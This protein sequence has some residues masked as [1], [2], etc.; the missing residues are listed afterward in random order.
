MTCRR[1]DAENHPLVRWL[2]MRLD[3]WFLTPQERGNPASKI[4]ALRNPTIAWTEGNRVTFLIDGATYFTRLSDVLSSLEPHDEVRFTDWRGD[5]DERV[6]HDGTS[7]A[8]LL[9]DACRRQVDV[10]GLLW[11]SH[12]D[13]FAFSSKENRRLAV[14]VSKSGGEVLLDERVRRAGSHHQKMFVVRHRTKPERDVALL[15][16]IDLS[17]GRHDD[18]RHHGDPQAIELDER[19]GPRPPWHDV[20]VE[21]QGPAVEEID[22][23]FHERW[24]DPTPLNHAGRARAFVSRTLKRDR[25]GRELPTRL[26]EPAAVGSHAVQILRTYPSRRPRYPFAPDGERS[27]ARAFS[28]ALARARSLIYIEDQYFWSKEIASLLANVL[29]QQP[30]L[31]LIIVVPRFPDKDSSMSGPPSRLAQE[32]AIDVVKSAGGDRVGIYDIENDDGTPVYVHAKV[33]VIDDVWVTVG[34][35]NLNRRSWTHDSEL[36]CAVIDAE[37]DDRVPLD[38]GG[39]DDGS[40]RFAR[41]LRLSLWSEHLGLAVD[42]PELLDPANGSELWRR[43]ADQLSI[44]QSSNTTTRR[45]PGHVR[46]H[47]VVPVPSRAKAWAYVVYRLIFD[48]DGRPL[49]LRMR[50]RY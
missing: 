49:R 38:P 37:L 18:A 34:S 31:Q 26:P 46:I 19:Y 3:D 5:G 20:Q 10:R 47:E 2:F 40:R 41:D 6:A 23:T 7:I 42:D 35:D 33:C 14:E 9:A 27:V 30:T 4:D 39:L 12:S 15:G 22:F 16:G 8:T 28:K 13:R 43:S 24:E 21:I 32:R 48:P 17:H 11:R 45:P 50:H 44:W 29:A 25:R 1:L 36:S